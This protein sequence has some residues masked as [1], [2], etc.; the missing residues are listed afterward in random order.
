MT[1]FHYMYV[2]YLGMFCHTGPLSVM[3]KNVFIKEYLEYSKLASLGMAQKSL[4]KQGGKWLLGDLA[5]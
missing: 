2:G 1:Y 5:K 4:L 3:L